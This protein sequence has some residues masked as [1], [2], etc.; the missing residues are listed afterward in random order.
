MPC[1][2]EGAADEQGP[3]GPGLHRLLDKRGTVSAIARRLNL[4]R[5]TV[6]RFRDTDLDELLTSAR[7]RRPNGVLEP[8]KAYLNARFAEA[9][10]QVSG[11]RLCLEIQARGYRGSRQVVRKHLAA[12]RSGTAETVRADVPSP[13]KI[14]SWIMRPRETLTD[15]QDERLLHVR[16]ACPDIARA[17]DLAQAFADLVRHQRGYLLRVACR[18]AYRQMDRSNG[19]H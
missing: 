12:L 2:E 18:T 15:S 4:D 1:A 9:Q 17:C 8:F 16:L 3:H 14:T 10:G 19:I 11:T 5:K 13:R 6:R 7:E